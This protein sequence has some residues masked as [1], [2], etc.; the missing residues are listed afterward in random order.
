MKHTII[1]L[2]K[3]KEAFIR[4]GIEE[5]S[6]R[7]CH[8]TKFQC[9]T[10]KDPA[11]GKNDAQQEEAKRAQGEALLKAVPAGALLVVL[12]MRGEQ[13]SSEGLSQRISSWENS[14]VREAVYLIGG[15]AGHSREVIERADLLL[16]FSAMTFTHDLVRLLLIE[17]LYRA[18]T[19]KAGEKYHK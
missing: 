2:G 17:Q 13:F 19:I 12:D 4:T 5:Y 10:I 11:S 16:S 8:Y 18:Y 7:L 15:A 3:T 9:R 14:G 6:R 1:F